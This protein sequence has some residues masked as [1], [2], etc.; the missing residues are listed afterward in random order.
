[1]YLQW[2]PPA[3][4]AERLSAPLAR[5]IMSISKQKFSPKTKTLMLQVCCEDKT[6]AEREIPDVRYFFR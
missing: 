6:G 2:W 5:T 3:K 1:V 4:K